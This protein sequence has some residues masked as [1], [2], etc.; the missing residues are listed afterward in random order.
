MT[1]LARLSPKQLRDLLVDEGIRR[2]FLVWDEDERV[3]RAS[4]PRLE[5]LARLLGD[6]H[7]DFDRH[8]GVFVQVGPETGVLQGAFIHRTCRGQ[9]AGGVRFW[10]YDTVAEFLRDGLRLARGTT[11]KNA[12]AGLWWGGGWATGC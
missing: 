12:L 11:H 2:F 5:P 4:H 9:A 8:E 6:D 1:D 3:V 10:R 7:R